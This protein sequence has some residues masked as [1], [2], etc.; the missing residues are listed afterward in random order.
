MVVLGVLMFCVYC[1][2]AFADEGDN[3]RVETTNPRNADGFSV[4]ELEKTFRLV[5]TTFEVQDNNTYRC[6]TATPIDKNDRDEVTL[7]VAYNTVNEDKWDSYSQRFRFELESNKYDKMKNAETN[8]APSGTYIFLT[9]DPHCMIIAATHYERHDTDQAAHDTAVPEG[10]DAAIED[11]NEGRRNCMLW[12]DNQQGSPDQNCN[13]KFQSLCPNV[14]VRQG[15][16]K[17]KCVRRLTE[18]L[19]REVGAVESAPNSE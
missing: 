4:L 14:Q 12:V 1:T 10:R 15:F 19:P 13:E 17:I 7:E 3:S 9:Q 2:E 8:G 16:S 5:E 18:H 6:I 11:Q